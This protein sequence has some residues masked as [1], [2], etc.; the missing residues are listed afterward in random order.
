MTLEGL[1]Y[2][3][4]TIGVAAILGT[5]V[6]VLMQMRQ[7]NRLLRN[8]AKRTQFDGVKAI[9]EAIYQTPGLADIM[10]RVMTEESDAPAGGGPKFHT[11]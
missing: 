1:Y 6:A 9:S 4:Q 3:A 7:T 8:Q 5:F 11:N 10:A 2:V